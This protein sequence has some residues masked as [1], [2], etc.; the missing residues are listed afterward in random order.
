MKLSKIRKYLDNIGIEYNYR[1]LDDMPCITMIDKL[2]NFVRID[3]RDKK[4]IRITFQNMQ[5]NFILTNVFKSQKEILKILK[6]E[7]TILSVDKS[8]MK[9]IK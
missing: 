9:K 8:F 2:N 6:I 5:Q 3:Q 4:S 1:I 7:D